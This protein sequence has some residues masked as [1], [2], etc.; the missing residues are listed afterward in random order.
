LDKDTISGWI[1]IAAFVFFIG[2]IGSSGWFNAI[3]YGVEYGVDPFIVSVDSKPKDCDFMH[4]PM[5]NKECHYDAKATAYNAVGEV[6][7]GANA[8][9]YSHDIKTGKPIVSYDDGKTWDWFYGADIP[10][11]KI[12]S[13]VVTWS[14]VT[15]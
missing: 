6:V 9:K 10:D 1:G 2:Y 3:W 15:D 13:V 7:G 8:P 14:K 11:T 5:G 12:K 4:A